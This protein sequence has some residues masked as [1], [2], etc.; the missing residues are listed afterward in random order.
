MHPVRWTWLLP[1]VAGAVALGVVLTRQEPAPAPSSEVEELAT[2]V[3]A[4]ATGNGHAGIIQGQVQMG[5]PGHTGSAFSF[6]ERGSWIMVPSSPQ[7]NA[8]TSNFLVSVWIQ[9]ESTPDAGE[10]YDIVRKGIA[11]TV[12]GRVQARAAGERS[13]AV[14]RQGRREPGGQGDQP[15]ADTE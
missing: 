14:Q 9:L 6:A 15:A 10:T 4:D 5:Q 1:I 8:G 12:P 7:L 13:S 11:Y 3:A 2:F